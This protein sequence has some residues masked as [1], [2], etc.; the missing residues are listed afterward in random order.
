M[1]Q[2][3]SSWVGESVFLNQKGQ[4]FPVTETIIAHRDHQDAVIYYSI[5]LRNIAN[6]KNLEQ[7]LAYFKHYDPLTNL[8]NRSLFKDK[9]H[10]LIASHQSQGKLVAILFNR[11]R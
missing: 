7:S 11:H 3:R 10:Q 2:E 1:L 6:I 9:L 5:A 8:P 4:R